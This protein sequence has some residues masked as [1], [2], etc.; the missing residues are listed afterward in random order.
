[1]TFVAVAVL[2][3]FATAN[4]NPFS[5]VQL[6]EART[7]ALTSGQLSCLEE[8]LETN[9][10]GKHDPISILNFEEDIQAENKAYSLGTFALF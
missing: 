5:S 2:G 7:S 3:P 4:A 10:N 8:D 9:E 1:L 6:S